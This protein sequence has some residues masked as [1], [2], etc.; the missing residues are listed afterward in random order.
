M[1]EKVD[2]RKIVSPDR[3]EHMKKM[4]EA[5]AQK[6]AEKK[7]AKLDPPKKDLVP[8]P[9]EPIVEEDEPLEDV[10]EPVPKK[11][12]CPQRKLLFIRRRH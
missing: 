5:L 2:K 11:T 1:S 9:L 6:N 8:A 4:R 10:Q 7:Q 3:L 12:R